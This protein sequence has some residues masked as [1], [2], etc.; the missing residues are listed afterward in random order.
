MKRRVGVSTAKGG[1]ERTGRKERK[2]EKEEEEEEEEEGIQGKRSTPMY[3]E[4]KYWPLEGENARKREKTPGTIPD[5]RHHK[6]LGSRTK[7]TG[8][9][10]SELQAAHSC[11]VPW[12]RGS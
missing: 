5:T 8:S 11:K 2:K 3:R 10:E 7:E 1:A 6:I 12:Y 4:T 9:W